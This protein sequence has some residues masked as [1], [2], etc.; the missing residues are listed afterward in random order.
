MEQEK[1]VR[2]HQEH[3]PKNQYFQTIKTLI[4]VI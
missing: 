1:V 3:L 2:V 4:Q